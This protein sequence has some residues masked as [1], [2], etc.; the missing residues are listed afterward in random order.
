MKIMKKEKMRHYTNSQI[1]VD[2]TNRL[3]TFNF[4]IVKY[5]EGI[6]TVEGLTLE[7][8]MAKIIETHKAIRPAGGVEFWQDE[9][10]MNGKLSPDFLDELTETLG[11]VHQ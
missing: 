9:N 2:H 7:Q 10:T 1:V 8:V 5:G 11:G 3:N 6:D 4:N